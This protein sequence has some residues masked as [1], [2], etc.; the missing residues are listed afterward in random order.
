MLT[1][2]MACAAVTFF[3]VLSGNVLSLPMASTGLQDADAVTSGG[4]V[5]L[6]ASQFGCK[7]TVKHSVKCING[8]KR[9]CTTT[10][11]ANCKLTT[12][13]YQVPLGNC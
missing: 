5:V 13:C 3:A 2:W 10:K 12:S 9:S 6:V 7:K 1:R 4:A 8:R 11:H